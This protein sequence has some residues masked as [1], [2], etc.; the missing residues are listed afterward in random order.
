MPD[1]LYQRHRNLLPL[2][3]L[4]FASGYTVVVTF[5]SPVLLDEQVYDRAFSWKHYAAFAA[6]AGCFLSYFVFRPLFKCFITS[7]LLLGVFNLLHFTPDATS[8][9]IGF[10][11]ARI[12]IQA[13]PFLL[14]ILY[15]LLNQASANALIR[16]YLLPAPTAQRVA[17]LHRERIDQFK[18]TFARKS[19]ESLGQIIQEKRLV[20]PAITAAQE[21]LQERKII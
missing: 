19:D 7:T 1:T 11:E 14:L 2:A 5:T 15:Y 3:L 16:K 10:D 17:N 8:V 21:L 13:F 20:L 12:S 4:L 18:E 6:I 9:G